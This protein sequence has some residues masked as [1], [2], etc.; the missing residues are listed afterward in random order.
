MLD[1][2]DAVEVV[3]GPRPGMLRGMHSDPRGWEYSSNVF[4]HEGFASSSP[5]SRSICRLRDSVALF[6]NF[7]PVLDVPAP[8]TPLGSR[9][10]SAKI[11]QNK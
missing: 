7:T 5:R 6:S 3:S 11:S 9:Q 10:I 4:D 2:V 1:G 8:H